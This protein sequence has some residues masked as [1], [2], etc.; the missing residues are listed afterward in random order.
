M[1]KLSAVDFSILMAFSYTVG[2][3]LVYLGTA[4]FSEPES[5]F[6]PV[7]LF[8]VLAG[9]FWATALVLFVNS[10]DLIGISRSNQWKNLQGPVGVLL[11]LVVLREATAVNP[12]L[13]MLAGVCIFC[14]AITLNIHQKRD[15]KKNNQGL[16]LAV[17]SGM[18]FGTVSLL[19]KI[20]TN[21]GGVY[22]Q[23]VIWSGSILISLLSYK[24]L[25]AK[26]SLYELL[27]SSSREKIIGISSGL[28]Y[29]GASLFMLLAFR[30]LES[31]I[32][33]NIIQLNF[34]IA[35]TLGIFYFKEISF[36]KHYLRIILG[37]LLALTGVYLLSRSRF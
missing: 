2:S 28:L 30:F 26:Q 12:V 13:A 8:S 34:L 27:I 32:A 18:L 29:F 7:L 4:I 20:V 21:G 33:F 14:S 37:L 25:V 16:L 17:G 19:N 31:S 23:Q 15:T 11:A 10:I 3:I 9:A 36:K 5:L 35:L 6:S 22:S 1:S 24:F